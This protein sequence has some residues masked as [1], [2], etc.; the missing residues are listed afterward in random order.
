MSK[1]KLKVHI[2]RIIRRLTVVVTATAII[3]SYIYLLNYF[4]EMLGTGQGW[5]NP[6]SWF[7]SAV[8]ALVVTFFACW[9]LTK[10]VQWLVSKFKSR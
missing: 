9:F 8:M 10:V 1:G 4:S 2:I 7:S 3:L 5:G 6:L